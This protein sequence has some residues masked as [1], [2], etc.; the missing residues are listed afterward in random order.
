MLCAR[1]VG[2]DGVCDQLQCLEQLAASR[3]LE[4]TAAKPN[5]KN[6]KKT[7]GKKANGAK[8]A[9]TRRVRG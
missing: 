9:G 2:I 5:G 3:E 4:A 7:N 6:G 8:T 1:F